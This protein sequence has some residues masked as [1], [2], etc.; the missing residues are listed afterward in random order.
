[1]PN[2]NTTGAKPISNAETVANAQENP[3]T[4]TASEEKT[5][6]GGGASA[7]AAPAPATPISGALSQNAPGTRPPAEQVTEH[8]EGEDTILLV[9]P[10]SVR[11]HT[12]DNRLFVF[13][14]GMN[15]V[16]RAIAFPQGKNNGFEG[17]M[18]YYLVA[19]GVKEPEV[20]RPKEEKV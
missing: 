10:R 2:N 19:N 3:S 14:K 13:Q 8:K 15:A 11:L 16:P 20:A 17:K 1:M 12:D 9:F 18:H 7:A 6:N 4:A 5:D